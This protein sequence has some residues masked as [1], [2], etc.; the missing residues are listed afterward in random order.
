MSFP[1]KVSWFFFWLAII[2]GLFASP[3][4]AYAIGL[5]CWWRMIAW[6]EERDA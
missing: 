6:E 3:G 4:A 2:I 1:R 5:A